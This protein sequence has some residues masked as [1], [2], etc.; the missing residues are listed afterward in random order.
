MEPMVKAKF[1]EQ[2]RACKNCGREFKLSASEIA[3]YTQRKAGLNQLKPPQ[4][5]KACRQQRTQSKHSFEQHS[6]ARLV[7]TVPNAEGGQGCFASLTP[8]TSPDTTEWHTV[9]RWYQVAH[10]EIAP[11]QTAVQF[12][13]EG[14]PAGLILLE[15]V[16]GKGLHV[17]QYD[18]APWIDDYEV[19]GR[20]ALLRYA[21]AQSLKRGLGG[22]F[23]INIK[24]EDRYAAQELGMEPVPYEDPSLYH[25]SAAAPLLSVLEE[26]GLDATTTGTLLVKSG[27]H[28]ID[29]EWIALRLAQGTLPPDM[30][31]EL[32]KTSSGFN[33][34]QF[35]TFVDN[36]DSFENLPFAMM[37]TLKGVVGVL[38]TIAILTASPLSLKPHTELPI[39]NRPVD[40][41][42]MA[43][44][45]TVVQGCQDFDTENDRTRSNLNLRFNSGTTCPVEVKTWGFPTYDL[46]WSVD[47]LI[48]QVRSSSSL[49]TVIVMV[50]TDFDRQEERVR[51]SILKRVTE[52]GG[53]VKVMKGLSS[54]EAERRIKE[55]LKHLC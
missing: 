1:Q 14:Q 46:P 49:G 12:N 15:E 13:V 7:T 29:L 43:W 23:T 39:N 55:L 16:A 45:K 11:H 2:T 17:L 35:Q 8:E 4:R 37:R 41:L 3:S 19:E 6:L 42:F 31:R 32:L 54:V 40:A 10:G 9:F 21:T 44:Q 51:R 27:S 20:Q 47:H 48:E 5:C 52:A 38:E 18:Y 28:D 25:F 36:S 26:V 34:K 50:T 24:D 22:R 53:V 33:W 30:L